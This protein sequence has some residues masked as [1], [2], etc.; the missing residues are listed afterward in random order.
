MRIS[1]GE[2]LHSAPGRSTD[3]LPR[4]LQEMETVAEGRRA[5][6]QEAPHPH[7]SPRATLP[8]SSLPQAGQIGADGRGI[9]FVDRKA[10]RPWP[11]IATLG[12]GGARRPLS[13]PKLA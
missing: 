5:A 9:S 7:H 13:P 10:W 6:V 3:K 12:P 2:D 4:Q 11:D 1:S 8:R